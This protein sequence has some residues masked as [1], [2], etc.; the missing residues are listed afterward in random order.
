MNF[1]HSK[2]AMTA[3]AALSLAFTGCLTDDDDGGGGGA[4]VSV[5]DVTLGAQNNTNPSSIDLDTWTTYAANTA[6][7][8]ASDIDLVFAVSTVG[9]SDSAALY[10]PLVAKNGVSGSSGFEFMQSWPTPNNTDIR[11]VTVSNWDDVDTQGEIS[12]LYEGGNSP[13]PAGRIIVRAGS[14]VVAK[15]DEGL[16]VLLRVESVTHNTNGTVELDGKAKW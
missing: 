4:S 14:T 5:K 8:H 7:S 1:K 2:F 9:S 3:I 15:S 11:T 6:A 12:S 10:S 16:L 13:S